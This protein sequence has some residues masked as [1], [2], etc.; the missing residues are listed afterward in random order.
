MDKNLGLEPGLRL[1]LSLSLSLSLAWDWF[2]TG[3]G[4]AWDWC[5]T[6]LGRR[7]GQFWGGGGAR[8]AYLNPP[9]HVPDFYFAKRGG[10]GAKGV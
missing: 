8:S 1:S 7:L 2:G 10:F 6:G 4:L 9:S 3:L 5:G